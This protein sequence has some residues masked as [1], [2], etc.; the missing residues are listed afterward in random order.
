MRN[1]TNLILRHDQPSTGS[2]RCGRRS[3]TLELRS[4]RNW[5]YPFEYPIPRLVS[6]AFDPPRESIPTDG[7]EFGLVTCPA[8]AYQVKV[9]K[10]AC[11]IRLKPARPAFLALNRLNLSISSISPVAGFPAAAGTGSG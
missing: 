10:T 3:R 7:R 8:K 2:D 1:S 4:L 6:A 11:V 9:E 5:P